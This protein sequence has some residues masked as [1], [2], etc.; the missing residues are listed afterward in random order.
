MNTPESYSSISGFRIIGVPIREDFGEHGLERVHEYLYMKY[1]FHSHTRNCF[2]A[3]HSAPVNLF[4]NEFWGSGPSS[5]SCFGSG[6]DVCV[7]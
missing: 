4:V 1:F 7:A 5:G 2:K 3:S 6:V